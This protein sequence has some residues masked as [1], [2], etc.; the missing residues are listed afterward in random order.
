MYMK[1]RFYPDLV[2][3]S[4]GI[5]KGE[6]DDRLKWPFP[7]KVEISILDQ[8]TK[9]DQGDHRSLTLGQLCPDYIGHR[10]GKRDFTECAT[11]RTTLSERGV[12]FDGSLVIK[13]TVFFD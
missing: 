9:E 6:F 4:L 1:S 11:Y 12:L 2:V 7:L 3:I 13:L 8:S 5:T 10:A